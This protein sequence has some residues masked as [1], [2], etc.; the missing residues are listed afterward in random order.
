MP[1][2]TLRCSRAY[3]KGS[4]SGYAPPKARSSA[5]NDGHLSHVG[6]D[7]DEESEDAPLVSGSGLDSFFSQIENVRSQLLHYKLV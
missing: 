5:A 7:E 6:P 1:L 4:S 3:G 2:N